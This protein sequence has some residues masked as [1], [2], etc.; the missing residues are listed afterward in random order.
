VIPFV[1]QTKILIQPLQSGAK[2]GQSGAKVGPKTPCPASPP[3]PCLALPRL[4]PEEPQTAKRCEGRGAARP[5]TTNNI[6]LKVTSEDHNE[7]DD[8]GPIVYTPNLDDCLNNNL[9]K[10]LVLKGMVHL[11]YNSPLYNTYKQNN[12]NIISAKNRGS[13]KVPG[14]KAADGVSCTGRPAL[15]PHG[16]HQPARPCQPTRW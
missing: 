2:K 6:Y 7:N 1:R 12:F 8:K 16:P 3:G 14:G 10:Q 9:L 13:E 11:M 4:G 15:P 5:S